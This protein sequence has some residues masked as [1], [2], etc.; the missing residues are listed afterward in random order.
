MQLYSVCFCIIQTNGH[1]DDLMPSLFNNVFDFRRNHQ[2]MKSKH[3]KI[4]IAFGPGFPT[5][6]KV[7]FEKVHQAKKSE[8]IGAQVLALKATLKEKIAEKRR[9]ERQKNSS[10]RKMDEEEGDSDQV[11]PQHKAIHNVFLF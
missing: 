5:G 1:R 6:G 4:G 3:K 11:L 7:N 8:R 2:L 10:L 9:Q